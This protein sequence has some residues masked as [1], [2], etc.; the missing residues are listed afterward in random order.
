MN[1]ANYN[2][3]FILRDKLIKYKIRSLRNM[4]II[5][6]FYKDVYNIIFVLFVQFQSVNI[7]KKICYS[8]LVISDSTLFRT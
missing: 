1:D 7:K 6:T 4:E 8:N 3:S 2:K 5:Y